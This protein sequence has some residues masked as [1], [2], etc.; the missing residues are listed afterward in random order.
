MKLDRWALSLSQ[1]TPMQAST[2]SKNK[3][4]HTHAHTHGRLMKALYK[5]SELCAWRKND[6]LLLDNVSVAHGRMDGRGPRKINFCGPCVCVCA[7]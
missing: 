5:S 2:C 6:I 3:G 4:T 7:S 1:P